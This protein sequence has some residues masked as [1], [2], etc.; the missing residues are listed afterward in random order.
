VQTR[1][2]AEP[3]SDN[4]LRF[5]GENIWS[6]VNYWRKNVTGLFRSSSTEQ[7]TGARRLQNGTP[8][9]KA[10]GNMIHRGVLDR[11]R[12]YFYLD[13]IN[14]TTE[15]RFAP[16]FHHPS[17][18]SLRVRPR[19]RDEVLR[20][21]WRSRLEKIRYPYPDPSGRTGSTFGS[22]LQKK[23]L[24]DEFL[25]GT[26][27]QQVRVMLIVAEEGDEE[28]GLRR[29]GKS[30]FNVR[31]TFHEKMAVTIFQHIERVQKLIAGD[32]ARH[33]WLEGYLSGLEIQLVR[34]LQQLYLDLPEC[35]YSFVRIRR[36]GA[37]V[38]IY[39]T[40]K[41]WLIGRL[42]R[43]KRSKRRTDG[44]AN[45]SDDLAERKKLERGT[46][47]LALQ[48]TA[49]VCSPPA[50]KETLKLSPSPEAIRKKISRQNR[51]ARPV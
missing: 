48:L 30:A 32:A 37:E 33:S 10:D 5:L 16:Q 12:D 39:E 28:E 46:Q 20:A 38:E 4:T 6:Q 36:D 31:T 49:L 2:R 34:E 44:V 17:P 22:H 41:G 7:M 45:Q 47:E 1:L 24:T 15:M 26:V 51:K 40:I 35:R 50:C 18:L 21:D 14:R 43:R 13:A 11:I 25:N 29:A 42:K 3:E 8:N 9:V 23:N 27:F 19:Y